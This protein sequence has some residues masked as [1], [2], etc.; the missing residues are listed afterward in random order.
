MKID[1]KKADCKNLPFFRFRDRG[2]KII[3]TNEVGEYAHLSPDDFQAYV[4]NNLDQSSDLY[5]ELSAKNFIRHSMDVTS[6]IGKY[7]KKKRYLYSGPSLHIMVV[8]LRCNQKCIYCHASAQNMDQGEMDMTLETA[9]RSLDLIFQTTSPDV[10]IEFQGGEPLVNWPVV[11]YVVKEA[12]KRAEKNGKNLELRLISNFSLMDEKK[13]QFLLDSDVSLCT[14]LD[15]PSDLHN[16]NRPL[17]GGDSHAHVAKWIK[18]FNKDYPK[19]NQ[20]GYIWKMASITTVSRYTL[21]Y[22]K[23]ILDEYIK[24][25][26]NSI[27]LRPLNPFGFSKAAWP[28]IGYTA[29]EYIDFYK[30]ALDYVI[31]L[32]RKGIRFEEKFAKTFLV[33]ILTE[34]D[35]NMMDYR[36]PCGAALG[37]LAYNYNGDVYTCDEGRMVSMMG[38]DNFKVGNIFESTYQDL[39][40]G[41]VSKTMCSASCMEGLAG[42][43]TCAYLPYCGVCPV[44]N[45]FEQGNIFGQ[46]PSNERCQ[47]SMATQD[48]IFDKLQDPEAK[49]IFQSWLI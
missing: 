19:L 37:Q 30:K 40:A 1:I 31:L 24:L 44:Y 49:D 25:G 13:Y 33:K 16:R 41:P 6:L 12:R 42:C 26:F 28:K 23:E 29:A 2:D 45:Y 11:E 17:F 47:I 3:I 10:I 9:E 43:S 4:N 15:G 46:M 32:N 36:S 5:Q 20:K 7:A 18:R 38:D 39:V 35:P 22:Y 8:T 34:Y 14:S 21:S 27:F 48:H